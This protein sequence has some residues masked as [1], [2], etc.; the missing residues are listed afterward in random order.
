MLAFV[1]AAGGT[2]LPVF[3]FPQKEYHLGLLKIAQSDV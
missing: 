3:V 2:V 1:N